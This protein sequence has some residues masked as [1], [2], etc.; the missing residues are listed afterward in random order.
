MPAIQL[1]GFN[2]LSRAFKVAG[3]ESS[4]ELRVT[5]REVAEPV[6]VS[7]QTFA[8]GRI[9]RIGLPWS[10]MRIGVT[11]HSVYIAPKQRGKR[12]ALQRRPNLAL[13][14]LNRAMLPGLEVNQAQVV[15]GVNEMLEHVGRAWERA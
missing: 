8:E 13:L 2:G 3:K 14:L 7:A 6:K 12:L 11:T 4:R 9:P 15:A 5:L 1:E 10:R